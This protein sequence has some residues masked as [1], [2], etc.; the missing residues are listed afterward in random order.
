MP[1]TIQKVLHCFFEHQACAFE[2]FASIN[3]SPFFGTSYA[4]CIS[5]DPSGCTLAVVASLVDPQD[6]STPCGCQNLT[7]GQHSF[8]S[9]LLHTRLKAAESMRLGAS[10]PGDTPPLT[11]RPGLHVAWRKMCGERPRGWMRDGTHAL[12]R[13]ARAGFVFFSKG[14]AQKCC[15]DA[16][17]RFRAG[18]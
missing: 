3:E 9:A 7:N 13:R 15:L 14:N 2:A 12:V 8:S 4:F 11:S 10:L 5:F 1:N 16:A 18:R 6:S 17:W